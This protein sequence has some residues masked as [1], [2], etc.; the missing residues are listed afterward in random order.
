MSLVKKD[1]ERITAKSLIEMKVNGK[2]PPK[3]AW[4]LR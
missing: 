2:K 3:E 4:Q 1:Y